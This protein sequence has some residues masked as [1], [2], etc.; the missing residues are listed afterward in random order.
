[1]KILHIALLAGAVFLLAER[2]GAQPLNNECLGAIALTDVTSFCSASGAYTNVGATPSAGAFPFCFPGPSNDV[3]FS[4]VAVATTVNISVIGN[5][6]IS[7]GG[8]LENPEFALYS[9][10]CAFLTELQC[11]SDAFGANV[12]ETFAGPLVVGDTYYIRVGAR[13]EQTGTFQLCVNNYNQVPD[14]N[15]DCP[16]GVVLCDKSP[17]TVES[18]IG[19][20]SLT[21]EIDPASC[22]QA[23]F[24]SAWYKWTCDQSGTLTFTLTP[25][26][27]TDDLDF[28]VYELPNGIDNCSGKEL[29]RCMA[30]GENVGEPFSNWA[31]CTGPTG[32]SLSS[33]DIV[34]NPGCAPASDNFVAALDMVAG[35]T[36]ALVINNFSNTGNGFSIQFGGT[37]TFLGP[38]P[39]FTVMPEINNQC[40]VDTVFVADNSLLPPGTTGTYTWTF[41]Q[42][43]IPATATGP[44][45]HQVVYASFGSKSIVLQVETDQ[46]CIVTE[47][48]T[49]FIEPCCDPATNLQINLDNFTD[50]I[51]FGEP[52]GTIDVSGTGGTPPY[53]FS[54]DGQT[55][56]PL[57]NFINLFA[58]DYTLYVQDIKGCLDSLTVTLTDPP[59]LLVDAGENV[60]IDLAESTN[61]QGTILTLGA[62]IDTFYWDNGQWLSCTNC[63]D[64]VATPFVTTV[65]EFTAVNDA[66]CPATDTVIVTVVAVRPVYIA[67]VFTPDFDGINDFFTAYG[68]PAASIIREMLI[69]DRW[70]GLVFQADNIPLNADKLGWDGTSGGRDVVSGVYA[71][72]FQIEFLDG[73]IGTYKGD[74]TVLR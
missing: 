11:S 63:F 61:L 70:G 30:A 28:A 69:F 56:V 15:S 23:E 5:T 16:T 58:G 51:C 71:Y 22:I 44:G 42:G 40:D 43:A 9:G 74:I 37:G 33:N 14:P 41:G 34:E 38:K 6:G 46:G 3:W 2:A 35:R 60:T 20:G 50:P 13:D 68:G 24:A 21:N 47:V 45:P 53:Q 62:V 73:V 1:M 29:L 27:P 48:R 25:T 17:F 39:D 18:L 65:F 4:F 8:T 32:L 57:G 26:N 59:Q 64:P 36:Y 66:G 49:I 52:T 72:L 67:N 12:T 31:D 7:T 10:N 54:I 55:F 19:A